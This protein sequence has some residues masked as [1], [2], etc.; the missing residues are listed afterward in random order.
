MTVIAPSKK[1]LY[2]KLQVFLKKFRGKIGIDLASENFKN[3]DFFWTKSYIGVDINKNLVEEG[4][5]KKNRIKKIGIIADLTKKN[6]IGI[7]FADVAVTTNTL[8]QIKEN[9]RRIKAVNNFIEFVK[10]KGGF[11]L[12][13]EKKHLDVDILIKIKKNFSFFEIIFY[14]NIFTQ[15]YLDLFKGE[16]TKNNKAIFFDKIKVGYLFYILEI[17][18]KNFKFINSKVIILCYKKNNNKTKSFLNKKILIYDKQTGKKNNKI[19]ES[20]K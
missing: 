11:F 7:N 12:Q 18:L 4:L 13:I 14:N 20:K 19:L 9:T 5:K 1:F 6:S 16:V 8:Y 2:R 17:L 15:Y 3:S 10:I